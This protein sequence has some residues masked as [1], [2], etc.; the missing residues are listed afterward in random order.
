MLH[1]N[2]SVGRICRLGK[3]QKVFFSKKRKNYF[4]NV[5]KIFFDNIS[6]NRYFC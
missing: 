2:I 4:F 5:H 6:S 1:L 3:I